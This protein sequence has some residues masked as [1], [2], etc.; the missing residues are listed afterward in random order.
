M[1]EAILLEDETRNESNSSEPTILD[2]NNEVPG[3]G[4]KQ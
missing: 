2:N 3:T 1:P 4:Q